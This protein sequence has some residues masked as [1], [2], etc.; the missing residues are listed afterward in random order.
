MTGNALEILHRSLFIREIKGSRG[1]PLWKPP[2]SSP[3]TV[4]LTNV[5]GQGERWCNLPE[6]GWDEGSK[7]SSDLGNISGILTTP[8]LH[9]MV[10]CHNTDGAYGE[11]TE[12]G[13][14]KKY[15]KAFL[16]LRGLSGEGKVTEIK[17]DGANGV[18]ALKAKEMQQ[19][20]RASLPL[21]VCNDG[22]QGKL[23]ERC[24]ADYVKINQCV[25]DGMT[26]VPGD[27]CVVYD[28]DADRVMY[29][30]V[31]E[32]KK[33]CLLD[34]D[35]IA[36]L[37][38]GYIKEKLD[39]TGIQ[40][41]AG[42]GIVQTAYANG[43]ATSYAQDVL[44]VPVACAKTGVKHLHHMAEQFQIGVYFEANGHGTVL[45]KPEAENKIRSIVKDP[46][47]D[48]ERHKAAEQL[49]SLVDLI[50]QAV[51][52]AISDML[53]VEV[54]L[55]ERGWGLLEWHSTYKDLPNRQRKVKVQDRTVIKTTESERQATA[56][57]GLQAEI[58]KLV[59]QYNSA[60]SFVRPSGT[61]DIVRVYAE[62]DSQEAADSLALAVC[63][64]VYDLAGGIGERP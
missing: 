52:D 5:A 37:I 28:G 35:K 6:W 19:H 38:A 13:Y 53:V 50:N 44:K 57:E 18:G 11:A 4:P 30:F 26:V 3:C 32:E 20:L 61:E 9:Y 34:G 45:I 60:R 46:E 43:S 64:K 41:S 40:L 39:N 21:T 47:V 24:G 36:T 55:Q 29:F 16:H 22:F 59:T 23:N 10:R 7:R 42:L 63:Q 1:N 33:F 14:Y 27:K 49:L 2:S 12:E 56:P 62:A 58:D 48:S 25:P 8:Q 15:S 31:D 54:I 17:L 51:G